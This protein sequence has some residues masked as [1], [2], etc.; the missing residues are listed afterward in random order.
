[1]T[2]IF[3]PT[4]TSIHT[5]TNESF[6]FPPIISNLRS[7]GR[8]R[9]KQAI[10]FPKD[11]RNPRA[12]AELERLSNS[13]FEDVDPAIWA[14]LKPHLDSDHFPDAVSEATRDVQF[15][16]KPQSINDV[17]SHIAECCTG[18]GLPAMAGSA[19]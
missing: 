5:L 4:N 1:M 2:K 3:A 15:R 14:R 13:K 9:A 12:A 19:Q 7:T 18:F 8:W 11:T 16:Y 10:R 6:F 17:L